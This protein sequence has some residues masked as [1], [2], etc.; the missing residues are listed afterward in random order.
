MPTIIEKPIQ[1]TNSK[2]LNKQDE[3]KVLTKYDTKLFQ[4][5]HYKE[6]SLLDS[7]FKSESDSSDDFDTD[8]N[9]NKKLVQNSFEPKKYDNNF[10]VKILPSK[11]K[12][13]I[14]NNFQ[15]LDPK[16]FSIVGHNI[17]LFA[18]LH[19]FA[20]YGLYKLFTELK[21]CAFVACKLFYLLFNDFRSN[22]INLIF[23]LFQNN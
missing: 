15:Y 17:I 9:H 19:S 16:T 20:F 14:R 11:E 3:P 2:P 5:D 1:T 13:I 21:F 23:F 8:I 4:K 10:N 12:V 6:T 7:S 22:L 18:I